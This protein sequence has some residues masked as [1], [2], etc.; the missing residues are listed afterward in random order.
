V[1]FSESTNLPELSEVV[2]MAESTVHDWTFN[3]DN[4]DEPDII[5]NHSG[6]SRPFSADHAEL[7]WSE[8]TQR[9]AV[10]VRHNRKYFRRTLSS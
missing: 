6:W 2:L 10:R 4:D 1:L 5:V 7:A 8:Q 3:E 9:D